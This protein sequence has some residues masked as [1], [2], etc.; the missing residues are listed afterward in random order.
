MCVCVCVCVVWCV[1]WLSPSL[2]V[3]IFCGVEGSEEFQ[4]AH[5]L[6]VVAREDSCFCVYRLQLLQLHSPTQMGS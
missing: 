2:I 4:M 1:C 6:L 5:A 3:V